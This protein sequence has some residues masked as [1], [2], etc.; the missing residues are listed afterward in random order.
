MPSHHPIPA[1]IAQHA[2]E[3]AIL[4][5]LRSFE[6]VAPHVTLHQLLRLDNR[7]AAHLDGLS[8]AGEAGEALCAEA[9]EDPGIG[10][11]FAATIGAIERGDRQALHHLVERRQGV[12][13]CIA[14]PATVA[15]QE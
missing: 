15:P 4:R 14:A 3:A 2:E 11:L 7:I 10:E 9:L 5:N 6:V 8:I 13:S 12:K 1:V